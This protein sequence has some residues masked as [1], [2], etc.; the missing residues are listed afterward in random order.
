[1]WC[2]ECV[3]GGRGEV[4]AHA[5]LVR[6]RC[7]FFFF[8]S[9]RRHTRCSRDWSSDVCSSDLTNQTGVDRLGRRDIDLL[10][11]TPGVRVTVILSPEHGLRGLDD[12]PGLPDAVDSTTG[13][14][15]YSL[16]GGTPLAAVAALDSVDVFLV[17][18]Q[19]VGARYYSYPPTTVVLMEEA[20]R[21]AKPV[22]VLDRPNPIR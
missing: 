12:R 4:T 11:G 5:G 20:T 3:S 14:P 19:D 7:M 17:D 13:L 8:S 10:R 15:I 6:E 16:Y 21:R 22:V 18:L 1:M 2:F 9:R